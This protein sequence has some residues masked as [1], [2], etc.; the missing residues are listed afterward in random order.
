MEYDYIV[1]GAGSAGCVVAARLS[2]RPH[3]RVLLVEAGPDIVPEPAS[4]SSPFPISHGVPGYRWRDMVATIKAPRMEG[5]PAASTPFPQA[6]VVG[7]GG[8]LMGMFALRG[9]PADYD[10]W[11]AGGVAGWGWR[12]VLPYFKRLERDLDFEGD[13]HGTDGP[14]P[15]RRYPRPVWSSFARTIGDA[16]EADG[17]PYLSDANADFRNGHLAMP[18]SSLP[19]R[20]MSSAAGY[21]TEVVRRRPN[22]EILSNVEVSKVLI[23]DGKVKGIAVK[24]PEET[25]EIRGRTV[26]LCAG[27]LKSPQI[28][29]QSGIGSAEELRKLGIAPVRDL[30]GVGRNLMNHA[31]FYL[32]AY[33]P[34]RYRLRG[35]PTIVNSLRYSSGMPDCPEQDMFLPLIDRTAWHALGSSFS[36]LGVSVYKPASRGQLNL[37]RRGQEIDSCIDLRIFSDARDLARMTD[38]ARRV[39]RYLMQA[40]QRIPGLRILAPTE[41]RLMASLAAPRCLNAARA[42]VLATLLDM[43]GSVGDQARQHAGT[44]PSPLMDDE[45]KLAEFV[46]THASPMFHPAGTC[47]MGG[48]TDRGAVVDERCR[49]MGVDGLR[50]ADASIMPTIVRAN[51]NIPTI[52]IGEKAADMIL[53]DALVRQGA[54]A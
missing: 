39:Y 52:M 43:P 29:M 2:E 47:R 8:S 51:T 38:G 35:G 20:R 10:E 37:V 46:Y 14:I 23:K 22:L 18:L 25:P 48:L 44:D 54:A 50:V 6:R 3:I 13:A 17:F 1:V 7:G 41:M 42:R 19:D 26:V 32:S 40:A 33:I 5:V 30:P 4:I 28:L 49:V 53:H 11:C 16:F 31:V 15:V 27:A 36:L 45:E 9:L 12:D 21:L 34:S 24:D